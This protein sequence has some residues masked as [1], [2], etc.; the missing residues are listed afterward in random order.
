MGDGVDRTFTCPDPW[1]DRQ[2][3]RQNDA[4]RGRELINT[5]SQDCT[6]ALVKKKRNCKYVCD[7][8][9]CKYIYYITNGV[10][11]TVVCTLTYT[12]IYLHTSY[13]YT[14]ATR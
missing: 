5:W 13:T 3:D 8:N 9:S 4:T 14:L 6:N 10:M 12:Y 11:C 1:A 7:H 2:T